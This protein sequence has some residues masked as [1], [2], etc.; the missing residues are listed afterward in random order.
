MTDVVLYETS[1]ADC[2]GVTLVFSGAEDVED[3]DEDVADFSDGYM[4]SVTAT[5]GE[6]LVGDFATTEGFQMAFGNAL[7]A[8]A[9]E[10]GAW[11]VG[12]T[13][14]DN[15]GTWENTTY[16]DCMGAW[17]NASADITTAGEVSTSIIGN[18]DFY[19]DQLYDDEGKYGF[20]FTA[21]T[22]I[23]ADD[24]LENSWYMPEEPSSKQDGETTDEGDRLDKGDMLNGFGGAMASGEVAENACGEDVKV[25]MGAAC[26]A[27]G[28]LGA[29][30]ALAI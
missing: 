3:L 25:V 29:A 7:E 8:D 2:A 27:A 12:A 14:S 26:L 22:T 19:Y 16:D 15:A 5:V 4:V 24:E 28:A 21:A 20:D 6:D 30:A 10:N 1:D 9:G 11:I 18:I 13:A 17:Y 23:A